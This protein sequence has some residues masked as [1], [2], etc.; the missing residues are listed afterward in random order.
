MKYTTEDFK[1]ACHQINRLSIF[2]NK[3]FPETVSDKETHAKSFL[4]MLADQAGNEFDEDRG[5]ELGVVRVTVPPVSAKE[6]G[7]KLINYVIENSRFF[8]MPAELKAYYEEMNFA[9]GRE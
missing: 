7:E 9:L 6:S 3:G 2:K 1:W 8:P 4:G 5:S